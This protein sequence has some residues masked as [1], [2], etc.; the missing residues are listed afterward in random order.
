[1]GMTPD[2]LSLQD[3]AAR[4]IP[5]RAS[6]RRFSVWQTTLLVVLALVIGFTVSTFFVSR[7]L[8]PSQALL[9]SPYRGDGYT[10]TPLAGW[11]VQADGSG[12][13]TF[14]D[15]RFPVTVS[16]Y[17]SQ[18]GVMVNAGS[19]LFAEF[20][21][22]FRLRCQSIGD[23]AA[24]ITLNGSVWQQSQYRCFSLQDG[25]IASLFR[26]LSITHGAK[27]YSIYDLT[28]IDRLDDF[29]NGSFETMAQSFTF[30]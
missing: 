14:S 19:A 21:S 10:I 5:P 3:L 25:G 8:R 22:S 18:F 6:R 11:H 7:A 2:E 13:V 23:V 29:S 9:G 4:S 17:A 1:M 27:N 26:V 20:G 12:G 16:R 28:P 30:N 24:T 15:P